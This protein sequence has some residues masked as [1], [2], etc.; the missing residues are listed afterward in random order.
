[1]SLRIELEQRVAA[2]AGKNFPDLP[3]EPWVRPCAD[4]RHGH[5]QT[6][7]AMVA[8]KATRQNPRELAERLAHDCL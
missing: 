6:H 3:A 5:F 4:E 8:A 2:W 1:M 7:L